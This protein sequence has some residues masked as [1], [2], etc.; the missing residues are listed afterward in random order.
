MATPGV[1]KGALLAVNVYAADE[2]CEEDDCGE[3]AQD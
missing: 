3:A 1:K 2:D